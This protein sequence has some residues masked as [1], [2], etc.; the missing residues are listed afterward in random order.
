MAGLGGLPDTLMSRSV[1]VRMR[2][3]RQEER[4]EPWRDRVNAPEARAIAKDLAAWARTIPTDTWPEM[5]PGVIDRNTDAWE[6][7]LAVADHAGG[8]WPLRAR[9]AAEDFVRGSKD[10][11]MSTGVRLLADL[12]AVFANREQL[13]TVEIISALVEMEDSTWDLDPRRLSRM[14]AKY[15]HAPLCVGLPR[16]NRLFLPWPQPT[17]QNPGLAAQ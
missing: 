11:P 7:L 4:V 14:L 15:D 3:R 12:R 17:R 6:A 5:P 10:V 13:S 9:A 2:R 16:C 1:V 8:D